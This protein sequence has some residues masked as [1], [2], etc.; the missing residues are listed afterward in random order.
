ML[1]GLRYFSFGRLRG[2]VDML[3]GMCIA[4]RLM[5]GLIWRA[6]RFRSRVRMFAIMRNAMHFIAVW[7]SGFLGL[8]SII[9]RK[10]TFTLYE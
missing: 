10:R 3:A 4:L 2:L 7:T 5:L 6:L 9:D 8:D 1:M